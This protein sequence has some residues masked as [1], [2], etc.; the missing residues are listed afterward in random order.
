MTSLDK[1]YKIEKDLSVIGLI[2]SKDFPPYFCSPLNA[3][4]FAHFGTEGIHFCIAN[5]DDGIENSPVY[6]VSPVMPGH[7][8]ELVGR[9]LIDFLRLDITCK[10]ASALEYISYASEDKFNEH[11]GKINIGLLQNP[12]FNKAVEDAIRILKAVFELEVINDIYNHVKDTRK[13]PVYHV[14]LTFLKE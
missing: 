1:L 10:D 6:V 9:N 8:V 14:N 7:Y 2:L 4:I 13:N 12:E 11:L 3:T 5:G